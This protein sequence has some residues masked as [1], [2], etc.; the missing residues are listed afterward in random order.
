MFIW[1]WYYCTVMLDG[2]V[3]SLKQKYIKTNQ[4]P[5]DSTVIL[6]NCFLT[7]L[8]KIRIIHLKHNIL[9]TA[10][11]L[12]NMDFVWADWTVDHRQGAIFIF[13][14]HYSKTSLK[15]S[16]GKIWLNHMINDEQMSQNFKKSSSKHNEWYL[17]R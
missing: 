1:I 6:L 7:F 4:T 10:I 16:S 15:Q 12:I 11:T 9:Q 17:T 14:L 3:K 8:L 2:K 13:S 5:L